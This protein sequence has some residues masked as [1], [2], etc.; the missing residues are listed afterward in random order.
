MPKPTKAEQARI[1]ALA[2]LDE[3]VEGKVF[4]DAELVTAEIAVK[5]LT[6]LRAKDRDGI[7]AKAFK[8]HYKSVVLTEENALVFQQVVEPFLVNDEIVLYKA[9]SETRSNYTNVGILVDDDLIIELNELSGD[10]AADMAVNQ[11]LRLK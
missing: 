4:F 8:E 2:L 1:D 3:T 5:F 9:L 10:E 6:F 7:Y 11:K